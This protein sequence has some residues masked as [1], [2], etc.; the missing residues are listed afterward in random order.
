MKWLYIGGGVGGSV[1]KKKKN[2]LNFS[3]LG[4][5]STSINEV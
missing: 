3:H 4:A 1:I 2:H 5:N